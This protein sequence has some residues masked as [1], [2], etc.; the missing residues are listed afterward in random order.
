MPPRSSANKEIASLIKKV[1]REIQQEATKKK[2]L[3]LLEQIVEDLGVYRAKAPH[4]RFKDVL[5]IQMKS[6]SRTNPAVGIYV[7]VKG[8]EIL[9]LDE[10][11]KP[12]IYSAQQ[13]A[14]KFGEKKLRRWSEDAQKFPARAFGRQHGEELLAAWRRFEA[15]PI[16]PEDLPK[17]A[18]KKRI[19]SKGA[20]KKR[21]PKKPNTRKNT[22]PRES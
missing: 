11:G 7:S 18:P 22:K 14:E 4:R 17:P 12:Y 19:P 5:W 6:T 9:H 2:S 10:E 20:K 16:K 3:T 15:D 21:G 1:Q 8:A 13:A